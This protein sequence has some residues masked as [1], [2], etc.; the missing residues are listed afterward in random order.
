[1]MVEEILNTTIMTQK[2]FTKLVEDFIQK[3]KTPVMEAIIHICEQQGVDPADTNR[4]LSPSLKA[5]LE[6]EAM[7]LNLIPRGNQL[8]V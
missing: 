5:K 1:M 6:A 2:R 3:S 7:E 4:L 8:P